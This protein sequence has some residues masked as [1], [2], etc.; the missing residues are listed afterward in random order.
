VQL[1]LDEQSEIAIA[2]EEQVEATQWVILAPDRNFRL[3]TDVLRNGSELRDFL[4]V[5]WSRC[6]EQHADES[7]AERRLGFRQRCD[8]LREL[9]FIPRIP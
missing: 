2:F 7:A 3:A 6:I 4:A 9:R 5:P 8:D 1:V